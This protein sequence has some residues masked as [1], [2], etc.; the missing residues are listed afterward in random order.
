MSSTSVS[1]AGC[2]AQQRR[3]TR[4]FALC[5]RW[6][7]QTKFHIPCERT[8]HPPR[9]FRPKCHPTWVPLCPWWQHYLF[10]HI[11]YSYLYQ[12]PADYLIIS[13][14]TYSLI[15]ERLPLAF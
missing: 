4:T 2:Q 11:F 1:R 10:F 5:T 7:P 12:H 3:R 15:E 6:S 13:E 9:T 14:R 8:P